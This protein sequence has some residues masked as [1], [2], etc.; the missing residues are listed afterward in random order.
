MKRFRFLVWGMVLISLVFTMILFVVAPHR[1]VMHF[2]GTGMADSWG[3]RVGLFLQP[4]LLVVIT[5]ICDRLAYST[6]KRDG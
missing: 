2:N 1:V 6:R 4:I 5:Y 3:N